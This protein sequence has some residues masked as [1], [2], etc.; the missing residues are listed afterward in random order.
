[1]EHSENSSI[2][3]SVLFF[4]GLVIFLVLLGVVFF[5]SH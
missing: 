3:R 1:M 5:P 2:L 4:I